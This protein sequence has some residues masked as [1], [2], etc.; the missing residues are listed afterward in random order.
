MRLGVLW[1]LMVCLSD[2]QV[3]RCPVQQT[4]SVPKLSKVAI[5]CP[6][7]EAASLKLKYQLLFNDSCVSKILLDKHYDPPECPL[8]GQFEVTATKSGVYICKRE[9][10]YPPPFIEDCHTTEVKVDEKQSMPAI[11]ATGPATNQSC[12]ERSPL[13]PELAMWVGCGVLLVYSLSITCITIV[14]WRK[15][16]RDDDDTNVYINT[17]PSELRKPHKV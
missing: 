6:S 10:I 13:I 17:R 8:S 4:I 15:L 2:G 14:I 12:S 3:M 7:M 5:S 9:V 1:M 16:K 11:N